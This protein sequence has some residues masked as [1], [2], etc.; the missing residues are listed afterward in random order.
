VADRAILDTDTLSEL[1]RGINQK[2]A[3]HARRYRAEHSRLTL[4]AVS[5]MEVVSGLHRMNR[6]EQLRRVLAE[7]SH[8]EVLPFEHDDAVIAGRIV[9]DLR[10][11]G[12]PIG[13]ADPMIASIAV[14]H[15]LTLVTGNTA[16]YARI[17]AL[18]Y[19]LTL[20]NWRN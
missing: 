17:Q 5:V 12:Q 2:V 18:G 14:R 8:A 20:D 6:E 7:L 15:G 11:T 9:A 4:T 16:H 13:L 19:A 10:R 3:E 1:L